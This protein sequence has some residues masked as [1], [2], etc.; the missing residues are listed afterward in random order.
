[1]TGKFYSEN[2]DLQPF[3]EEINKYADGVHSLNIGVDLDTIEKLE[4]ELNIQIPEIYKDFLLACNG[5]EL[6]I[7]GTILSEIYIPSFGPKQIGNSY[8]NDSFKKE[9]RRPGMPDKYLIIADLNYGDTICM[10]I[11]KNGEYDAKIIQWDRESQTVS[12]NWDGFV[13]WIMDVLDEGEMLV[14]Y[15]GNEKD[16]EF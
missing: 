8:L 7:P 2:D 14:D 4:I 9:R 3:L 13:E 10:E 1:M 16:L 11:E 15:N 6:F 12:R 5:G